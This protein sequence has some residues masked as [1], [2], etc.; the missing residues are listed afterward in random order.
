MM[1]ELVET[2]SLVALLAVGGYTIFTRLKERKEH[3]S[4]K[5]Q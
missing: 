3:K 2:L 1:Y 5:E 4:K